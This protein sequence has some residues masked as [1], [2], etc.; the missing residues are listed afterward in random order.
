[1][2]GDERIVVLKSYFDGGG[3]DDSSQY[4]TV[5]LASVSAIQ[6][7][8]IAFERDWRGILLRYFGDRQLGYLHT[9]DALTGNDIYAGWGEC[10]TYDFLSDCV[11]AAVTHLLEPK[12]PQTG[13]QGKYGLFGF[14]IT[15]VLRPFIEHAKSDPSAPQNANEMLL[16]Q[17]VAQILPWS[18]YGANPRCRECHFFFDQGEPYYGHLVQL[19]ESK[20][21]MNDA[22]ELKR[23]T[24]RTEA[25]MRR[26][27]ALQLADLLAW[28]Y[29]H[30]FDENK[31]DWHESILA[32]GF[33]SQW[34]DETT[35]RNNLPDSQRK[36]NSWG[37][38]K[39][40]ASR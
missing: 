27:S 24:G 26:V 12:N 10:K 31:P 37:L 14:V 7:D 18:E 19:L 34:V 3:Q 8:W 23:I 15:I 20:K 13:F 33:Q 4:D 32:S 25:D 29:S 17:S 36:W 21:A 40:R 1:M 35:I 16:R 2:T 5:T 9:T 39:R 11:N 30:K 22:R 28:S 38:T 6:H